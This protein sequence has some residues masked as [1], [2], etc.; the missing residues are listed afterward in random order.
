MEKN[1]ENQMD[2]GV[3]RG[4]YG[5]VGTLHSTTIIWICSRLRGVPYSGNS[6]PELVIV[7]LTS[8]AV[9]NKDVNM[10]LLLMAIYL[11]LVQM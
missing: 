11:F 6:K 5:D 10:Q 1:M 2:A 4:L 8:L 9:Y 7:G 3:F